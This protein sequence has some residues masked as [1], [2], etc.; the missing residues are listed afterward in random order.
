MAKRKQGV[1]D[2]A[3]DAGSDSDVSL[4]DVDFD[5]C[6]PN[7]DIDYHALKKLLVQLFQRDAESFY[8]E[9]L[10]DLILSQPGIGTTVKTDGEEGDPYAV[11]TAIS[12]REKRDHPAI[13]ALT[14]Y[15]VQKSS[16]L[17]AMQQDLQRLLDDTT[18]HVGLVLCERLINM[19]VQVIPHM[20]RMLAEELKA[21][22]EVGQP[23]NF[24]HLL[25]PS[26]TYHLSEEEER[27][28]GA[29]PARK[30][31]TKK[32]KTPA[33]QA[34]VAMTRPA[35]GV[36]TFHPEDEVIREAATHTLDYPFSKEEPRD[37]ESFGLDTRGRLML[38]PAERFVEM[39]RKMGE[40]Y[41]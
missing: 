30:T 27:A 39:V 5:F 23:Y 13:K 12:V 19:P 10:T 17:P 33:Q 24:T 38:V 6:S 22:V 40:T 7:P 25:I 11:L 14:E 15:W 32:V 4:V 2:A 29:R 18:S 41:C 3:G 28:L 37:K 34:Q 8:L 20:Y 1:E 31:K 26:R 21:A 9:A 36:Y 16:A 35:D